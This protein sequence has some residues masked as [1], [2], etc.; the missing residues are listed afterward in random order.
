MVW[1][2]GGRGGGASS[3]KGAPANRNAFFLP[4][5]PP[6][7]NLLQTTSKD[8]FPRRTG[9]RRRRG[10]LCTSDN[11]WTGE[12]RERSSGLSSELCFYATLCVCVCVF[13]TTTCDVQLDKWIWESERC[14]RGET[15]IPILGVG[16]GE[17]ALDVSCRWCGG[18]SSRRRKKKKKWLD[19]IWGCPSLSVPRNPFSFC[20]L[21]TLFFLLPILLLGPCA[22]VC[23]CTCV[24][25][26]VLNEFLCVLT[27]TVLKLGAGATLPEDEKKKELSLSQPKKTLVKE[28]RALLN[29]RATSL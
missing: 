18:D 9:R 14:P 21:V 12:G 1:A 22:C 7:L 10:R 28:G 3:S 13:S 20:G 29:V 16:G 8:F 24:R 4:L 23:G 19:L 27:Q 5:P 25:A 17:A 2:G 6:P 15:S 11:Q 26:C